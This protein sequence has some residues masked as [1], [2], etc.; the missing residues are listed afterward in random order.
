[1]SKMLPR[2]QLPAIAGFC[3]LINSLGSVRR[4]PWAHRS[5]DATLDDLEQ[6]NAEDGWSEPWEKEAHQSAPSLGMVTEH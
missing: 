4:P 6:L 5:L 1:M 2:A 3:S